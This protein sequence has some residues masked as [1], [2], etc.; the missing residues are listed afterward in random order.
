MNIESIY[1]NQVAGNKIF[2][3]PGTLGG[4]T[5]ERDPFF[6]NLE[7]KVSEK[8]LEITKNDPEE[9][10]MQSTSSGLKVYGLEDAIREL[11]LLQKQN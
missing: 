6:E 11:I 3:V 1:T 8:F 10:H 5:K 7:N 4:I 9:V 2:F